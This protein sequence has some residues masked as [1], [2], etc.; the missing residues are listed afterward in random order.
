MPVHSQERARSRGRRRRACAR[1]R[2]RSPRGSR[3]RCRGRPRSGSSTCRC[4]RTI[5]R[6]RSSRRHAPAVERALEPLPSEPPAIPGRAGSRRR[7]PRRPPGTVS[8]TT[9]WSV[10]QQRPR[11]RRPTRRAARRPRAS[12]SS[13]RSSDVLD[14]VEPVD[15]DVGDRQPRRRVLADE[16]ERRGDDRPVEPEPAREP[17]DE[18][19]LPRAELPGQGDRVAGA[20]RAR[21]SPR[22]SPRVSSA[23][24][25][26]SSDAA[27]EQAELLLDRLRPLGE[28]APDLLEVRSERRH[29]PRGLAPAVQDRRRMERRDDRPAVPREPL[30]ADPADR[31]AAVRA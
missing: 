4:P 2:T 12:S 26:R 20:Q 14:A 18:R 1:P 3:A 25:A 28:R 9:R 10:G 23:V 21:R 15:V 29:L 30:A 11:R 24:G 27:S 13:P 22:R 17:L 19:G 7:A 8:S 5:T 31:D 6:R 16:R